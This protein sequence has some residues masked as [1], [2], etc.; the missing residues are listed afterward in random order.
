[1]LDVDNPFDG[2]LFKFIGIQKAGV[3]HAE[4]KP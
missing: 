1:M 3:R 2:R 4:Q